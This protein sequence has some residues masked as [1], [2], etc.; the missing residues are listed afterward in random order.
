[1]LTCVYTWRIWILEGKSFQILWIICCTVLLKISLCCDS[2]LVDLLGNQGIPQFLNLSWRPFRGHCGFFYCQP[3][4]QC[5]KTALPIVRMCAGVAFYSEDIHV[6][7]TPDQGSVTLL[8]NIFIQL[9]YT[10]EIPTIIEISTIFVLS[11]TVKWL[12]SSII[13]QSDKTYKSSLQVT[14]KSKR[15]I[16]FCRK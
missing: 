12:F 13:L 1:M 3:H 2:S 9:R 14:W 6:E 5:F 10:M 11:S 7:I 4:F 15:K 8:Q 16:N